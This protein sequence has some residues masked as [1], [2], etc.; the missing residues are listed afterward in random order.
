M[1]LCPCGSQKSYADCCQPLIQK[2]KQAESAEQLLR[3]RY[4]AHVNKEV[5]YIWETT[6]PAQR[7]GFD[8]NQVAEWSKNSEWLGLEIISTEAGQSTDETGYVEFVARYREKSKTLEHKEIAEFRKID[9]NWF[10]YDGNAPKPKQIVRQGPKVG[11][12]DPCPCGSGKKYKK[13]CGK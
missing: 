7:G 13:C 12:N 3:A 11:R 5:D 1:D 6:H 8:R 9:D 10:F 2:E 4:T